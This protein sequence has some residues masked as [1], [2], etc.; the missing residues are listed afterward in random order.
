[1]KPLGGGGVAD[2]VADN[3]AA[4]QGATAPVLG[5]VTGTS[6]VVDAHCLR[7]CGCH[8]RPPFL[9]SPISSLLFGIDRHH[10]I[11]HRLILGYWAAIAVMCPNWV[12]GGRKCDR[13]L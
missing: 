3:L 11:A 12:S 9:K 13:G 4:Y 1:M 10:R 2:Q 7:S 5:N 8:S 6:E